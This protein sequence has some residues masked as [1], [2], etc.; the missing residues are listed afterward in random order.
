MDSLTLTA[1]VEYTLLVEKLAV[2]S[3]AM[4]PDPAR[5][6]ALMRDMETKK[7]EIMALLSPKKKGRPRKVLGQEQAPD[8][9][10]T[11]VPFEIDC[12]RQ[13]VGRFPNKSAWNDIAVACQGKPMET[14]LEDMKYFYSMWGKI[15]SNPSNLSWLLDWYKNNYIPPNV[16]TM[17]SGCRPEHMPGPYVRGNRRGNFH[18]TNGTNGTNGTVTPKVLSQD[19]QARVDAIIALRKSLGANA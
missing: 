1:F 15:S 13:V 18:G 7:T 2:H 19:E 12:V 11:N 4:K 3:V 9:K 16:A 14:M 17:G 10:R 5:V 8:Q 6:A